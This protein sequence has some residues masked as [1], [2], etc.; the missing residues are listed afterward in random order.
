MH[1]SEGR[2]GGCVRKMKLEEQ[3]PFKERV[4][5]RDC[6]CAYVCESVV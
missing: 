1:L 2:F 3:H 5:E 6:V 4:C